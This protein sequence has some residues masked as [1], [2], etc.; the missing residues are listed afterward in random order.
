MRAQYEKM[1]GGGLDYVVPKVF[2]ILA[3]GQTDDST[4]RIWI[5]RYVAN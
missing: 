4:G 1:G 5:L 2:P 3:T